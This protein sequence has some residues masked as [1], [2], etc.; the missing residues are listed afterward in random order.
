MK[1]LLKVLS[2]MALGVL[3]LGPILYYLGRVEL[4][5]NKHLM[6]AGTLV[7]FAIAPFWMKSKSG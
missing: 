5:T 4:D 1:I 7:W 2:Y 6:L 3:I